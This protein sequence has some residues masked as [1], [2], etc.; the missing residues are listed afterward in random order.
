MITKESSA[1]LALAKHIFAKNRGD[2]FLCIE[3]D[4]MY[5][6]E[7]DR[8]YSITDDVRTK[9][10]ARITNA[11]GTPFTTAYPSGCSRG[12]P[13]EYI[14]EVRNARLM[15]CL[16]FWQQA[17]DEERAAKKLAITPDQILTAIR[18]PPST[19]PYQLSDDLPWS[20]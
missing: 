8:D 10:R 19:R 4:F 16:L 12:D 15:A 17:L 3:M 2:C 14:D 9:M 11:L 18:L 1:W 6:H 20:Y 5:D 7:T 13:P